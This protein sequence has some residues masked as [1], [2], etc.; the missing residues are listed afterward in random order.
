MKLSVLSA[1]E[2]SKKLKVTV[3]KTGRLGFTQT[4]AETLNLKEMS[5]VKF[6]F[7]EERK[8]E[9]ILHFKKE[10]DDDS[11]KAI[12]SGDYYYLNT[13]PLFDK[14][15]YDYKTQNII[16]DL[17]EDPEAKELLGD[18]NVYRLVPRKEDKRR[19]RPVVERQPDNDSSDMEDRL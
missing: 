12:L 9:P 17:V 10:K 7:D 8:T 18:S 2:L 13:A 11:F 3:Q 6:Y 1:K 5:Y 15:G 16:C 19:R 14:L 4:T